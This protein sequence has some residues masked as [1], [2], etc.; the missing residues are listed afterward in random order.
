M[1]APIDH[2][3]IRAQAAIARDIMAHVVT[4]CDRID[5]KRAPRRSKGVEVIVVPS[6]SHAER[7]GLK[8]G[9]Q[10]SNPDIRVWWPGLGFYRLLSLPIRRVTIDRQTRDRTDE[11]SLRAIL[12]ARQV[13]W[14]DKAMWV[15]F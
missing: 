5:G 10:P 13:T 8:A 14:G 9:P 6:R 2:D 4:L 15:E 11:G 1:A 12:R 7:M 3:A